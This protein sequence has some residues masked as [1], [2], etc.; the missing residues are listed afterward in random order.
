M[1]LNHVSFH[2]FF[3]RNRFKPVIEEHDVLNLSETLERKFIKNFHA[4]S[5]M[6]F[7]RNH[8]DPCLAYCLLSIFVIFIS[9]FL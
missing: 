2:I 1:F 4:Q 5:I 6:L 7:A 9:L 8:D 3:I